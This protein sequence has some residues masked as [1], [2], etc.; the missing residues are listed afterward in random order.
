LSLGE[1]PIFAVYKVLNYK[2]CNS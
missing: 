1:T 2:S